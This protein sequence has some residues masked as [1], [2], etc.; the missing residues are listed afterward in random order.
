MKSSSR[1][2]NWQYPEI[3]DGKPTKY[4]W[5]VQ[6]KENFK[7][8]YNTDL[9]AFTYINAK[10]G[11]T[12][13]ENVQIG[14]HCSIYSTSTIDNK[15][16]AVFLKKNCR[17]GTHSTI[18]PGVTVGENAVIGA[19]SF[20][21]QD[22]PNGVVVAGVPAKVIKT[23]NSKH[24]ALITG[25]NIGEWI[26]TLQR[27]GDH[28]IYHLPQYHLLAE[29]MG[30]GRP[31]LFCYQGYN[32]Y[33]A[34]PFLLRPIAEVRGL[35][36]SKWNDIT[37]VYGYPGVIATIKRSDREAAAFRRAF[38]EK[39]RQLFKQLDVISFFSRTNPL[40]P[41]EW[42]LDG[43]MEIRPLSKTVAIDL[44]QEE[45]QQLRGMGKTHRY[46]IRKAR[47][48][49]LFVEEDKSF[50]RIDQFIR[51]YNETMKRN[52]ADEKYY[53]PKK[54]Y[55]DLKRN[56]GDSV[57]LY[58]AMRKDQLVS[59][60]VFFMNGQIIQFHLGCSP[61][62]YLG[63]NGCKLILDEIRQW[64]SRNHFKWLHLGGGVGSSEDDLFRYKAGFSKVRL[65]FCIIQ[66]IIDQDVY[67]ELNNMRMKWAQGNNRT[68]SGTDFFPKYR[69]PPI[70]KKEGCA[71]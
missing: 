33:A 20:V 18:M 22:V 34:L 5:V 16:G 13:E 3:E 57:K 41:N 39:L 52:N 30:E 67:A 43:F 56:F 60:S 40:L 65:P 45:K 14:S 31:Y 62:K 26:E 8:G 48:Q 32:N 24:Y 47:R 50:S 27:C 63:L 21:N 53:F 17:V 51:I 46:H 11:V 70:P 4:N 19:H 25:N 49:G 15:I 58:F 37:T 23:V 6:Y 64:G 42:L 28:D 36:H 1:F 9:G 68:F 54:Y 71:Y 38:Q 44:A 69:K 7:L 55:L 35:N 10:H 66:K 29:K 2:R 12:I 61:T 59:A